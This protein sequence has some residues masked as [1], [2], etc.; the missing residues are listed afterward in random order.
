MKILLTANLV[1][2]VRGGAEY[3]IDNLAEAL[4]AAGHEVA[5]LRLPFRYEPETDIGRA[6]DYAATLN[7]SRPSGVE[8]D[9]V[10]SLQFPGWGIAHPEHHVWVMHQHRAVYDL[11]D[12]ARA[13]P[14]HTRFRDRVV[15]F[16]CARLGV[17]RRLFAN[18]QRVAERLWH[19]NGLSAQPLYHPPP[20]AERFHCER[21]L[22]FVFMPSRL[23]TLKR[24]ALLIETAA[25]MRSPM[26]IVLAGT[27]GQHRSLQARIETLGV[28]HRVCLLGEISEREKLGFYA[29][30]AAVC[31]PARDEDYGYV[32]LEAMLSSKPV[33]TCTDS[34]GPLEFVRDGENGWVV[35]PEPA[36]LAQR[37]DWI[38]GH[39]RQAEEMGVAGRQMLLARRIDWHQVVETLTR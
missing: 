31:F 23:E 12:A 21:A 34:G 3:H 18:S 26:S 29:R 39:R 24:Q 2:F 38:A 11:F 6:M 20:F 30:A 28:G 1:P 16:D 37:I 5:L 17:A 36:A 35:P 22:P 8:I 9:R 4:R 19:Y 14:E 25:L 13:S 10:I 7:M 15:A 27:G 32:T 33:L